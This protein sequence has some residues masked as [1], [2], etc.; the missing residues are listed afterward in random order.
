MK[1]KSK[2]TDEIYNVKKEIV[3]SGEN[4]IDAQPGYDNINAS[5]VVNF[6]L[7]NFGA[8]KFASVTKKILEK[9]LR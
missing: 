7:N 2:D 3:L 1:L 6:K 8:K 4:L 5:A 9:D